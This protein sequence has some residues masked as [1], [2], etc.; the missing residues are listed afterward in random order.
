MIGKSALLGL[1]C[2]MLGPVAAVAAAP[3]L[4][5]GANGD[6]ASMHKAQ[7]RGEYYRDR[8]WNDDGY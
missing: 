6:A 7:Y 4:I 3:A 2:L 5:V 1:V 8:R